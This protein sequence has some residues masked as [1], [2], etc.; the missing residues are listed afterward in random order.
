MTAIDLS[1]WLLFWC[2][3]NVNAW[4][5]T[6]PT[7]KADWVRTASLVVNAFDGPPKEANP[8]ERITWQAVGRSLAESSTYRQ[9]VSTARKMQ[10]TKYAILLAKSDNGTVIGMAELGLKRS[11]EGECRA[12]IGVLCVD[13]KYQKKGVGNAL[14]RKCQETVETVWRQGSISAE[15]E[16][17]NDG[18]IA[19][20]ESCGFQRVQGTKVMVNLRRGGRE[21]EQRPHL[22]LTYNLTVGSG[23][24]SEALI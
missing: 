6:A 18:A 3:F 9:Y 20:F 14:V 17:S 16:P 5:I 12:I 11:N 8:V 1:T 19:F 7:S 2:V 21:L 24:P 22:L 13:E 23:C 4:F 15:V 10:G